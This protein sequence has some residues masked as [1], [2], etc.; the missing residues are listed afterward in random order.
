MAVHALIAGC[1][2]TELT[3]E[4]VAFFRD[5]D[6]WGLILFK[7]NCR[8]PDQVRRLTDHFRSIVGRS[9]A[10]VLIDQEGG[11][12]QRVGP[13]FWPKYPAA[14]T[15]AGIAANDPM[16]GRE[17]ARLGARLMAH[18]LRAIGVTVNCAPVL[19]VPADKAHN[20]IGDRAFADDPMQVA[21]LGRA[22]AEGHLAGAVLPVIKHMPG[23]GRARVDSHETL[24]VVEAPRD[25]LEAVDFRPF[26]ILADMPL[27]M[28]AH[29][30]YSAVDGAR[31]ATTSRKV[32]R[33]VIRGAIGYDGLVMTDDLGMNALAGTL[34]ERAAACFRAG[35]DIVL[36]CNG[37]VDEMK[38]VAA[39]TPVLRGQARRRAEAALARI[40]HE[41]E[42][43]DLAEAQA[44]FFAVLGRAGVA[45]S[46]A[47]APGHAL[48]L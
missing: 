3:A 39:E 38:A 30:V 26:R 1:A 34:A 22:V 48:S 9:D 27:A 20:V 35:C 4:E 47:F 5:L 45:P 6:P 16:V 37:T 11:R 13:P 33:E 31:P 46:T 7:R 32:M 12:V 28:T 41:P 40:R 24:P 18:D 17:M 19:D 29:V 8:D 43:L 25:S 36:H 10:P 21:L 44:R 23:H 15:F 2:G 14:R 42:P